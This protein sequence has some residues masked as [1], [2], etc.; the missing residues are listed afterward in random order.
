MREN[1]VRSLAEV[2]HSWRWWARISVWS[3]EPMV[4]LR[5]VA[6]STRVRLFSFPVRFLRAAA[7]M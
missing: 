1:R 2:D 5:I 7:F 3:G 6:M 4:G